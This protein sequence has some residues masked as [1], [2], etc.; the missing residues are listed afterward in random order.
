[1]RFWI[2]QH[3]RLRYLMRFSG[4]KY[5]HLDK[6]CE[7]RQRGCDHCRDLT[8][9]LALEEQARRFEL[10]DLLLKYLSIYDEVKVYL[11]PTEA[12]DEIIF[13]YRYQNIILLAV[14][15]HDEGKRFVKTVFPAYKRS[16]YVRGTEIKGR[17]A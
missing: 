17:I 5:E 7:F 14:D 11:S 3:A 4:K 16:K 15:D 13:C 8:H 10:N 12:G 9:D 1:M 2:T 6:E